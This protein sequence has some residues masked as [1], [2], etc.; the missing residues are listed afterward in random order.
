[1][2]TIQSLIA[3]VRELD[4]KATKGPWGL[5]CPFADENSWGYAIKSLKD[6]NLIAEYRTAAPILAEA[7]EIAL[8]FIE[9]IEMFGPHD[10]LAKTTGLASP[11]QFASEAI[12]TAK[13]A[14]AKIAK[15]TEGE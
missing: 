2:T 7:L 15:L 4:E 14:L 10:A 1:M 3:R 8:E 9:R 5:A 12:A 13:E 11:E 6:A